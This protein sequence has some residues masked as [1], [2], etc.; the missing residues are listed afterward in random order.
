MN[1]LTEKRRKRLLDE[2]LIKSKII[3][4]HIDKLMREAMGDDKEASELAF[5]HLYNIVN[6]L[7]VKDE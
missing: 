3:I 2:T 5:K 4:D 7:K 6:S 1:A